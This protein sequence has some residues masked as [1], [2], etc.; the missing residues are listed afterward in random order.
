MALIKCPECANGV[1]TE[2]MACPQCGF[3]IT[4][5]NNNINEKKIIPKGKVRCRN[6]ASIVKPQSMNAGCGSI[7][8]AILLLCLGIIPGIIYI[9]WESSRKQCPKC[10]LSIK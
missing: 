7:I 5:Q 10:K 3:P 2:A 6:C 8:I 4:Q 1:S 9:I